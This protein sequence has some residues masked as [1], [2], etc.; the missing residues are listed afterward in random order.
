[1]SEPF[2]VDDLRRLTDL[3]TD[4]L[5]SGLH[6]DWSVPAGT[7]EWSCWTTADHM[8]DCV[9]SYALF[10]ASRR[11]DSYPPFGEL[12]ALP[13]AAPTD[14]VEGLQAVCTMLESVI[15]TAEP[16]ARAVIFRRPTVETGR[17]RDFAARGALEMILHTHDIC[18]GLGISFDP[19]DDLCQLLRDHTA[20]W[21]GQAHVEPTSDPWADLLERSGRSY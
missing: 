18:R 17:P 1:V 8:T 16:D 12:H 3:V 7:L 6:R 5:R 4:A 10:F 11:Q 20:R 2:S 13:D 15:R 14:L 9:F 19:P 21:P